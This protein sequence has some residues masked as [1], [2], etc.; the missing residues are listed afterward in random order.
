MDAAESCVEE[1]DTETDRGTGENF[2]LL[3]SRLCARG[4]LDDEVDL[5][6]E[7]DSFAPV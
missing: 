5:S 6:V 7:G 1:G 2:A 3:E 4:G